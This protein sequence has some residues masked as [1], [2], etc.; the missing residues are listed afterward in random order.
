MEEP[1]VFVIKSTSSQYTEVSYR[2][3]T[4]RLYFLFHDIHI[5]SVTVA[6]EECRAHAL[7]EEE[8]FE[9]LETI[10]FEAEG[11]NFDPYDASKNATHTGRV[12]SPIEVP[13]G[14]DVEIDEVPP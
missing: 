5:D 12:T 14:P 1:N 13:Q 3:V 10:D 4:V 11:A 8:G 2:C 7:A 6:P 9:G